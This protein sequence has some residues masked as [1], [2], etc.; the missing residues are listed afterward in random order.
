MPQQV[1]SI[2]SVLAADSAGRLWNWR[3]SPA[4][5]AAPSSSPAAPS[6][7][8]AASRPL[9]FA[10][11]VWLYRLWPRC[12]HVMLLE[13]STTDQMAPVKDFSVSELALEIRAPSIER[14]IR[15][16]IRQ[17]SRANP[18]WRASDRRRAARTRY[19]DQPTTVYKYLS[20]SKGQT[21]RSVLR[22]QVQGTAAIDKCSS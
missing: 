8:P 6:S 19:R 14:E 11:W 3:T 4:S 5:P 7:S 17:I 20:R 22:S 15:D 21:W 16:R 9:L 1:P 2:V 13:K 18:L 10:I 12:L